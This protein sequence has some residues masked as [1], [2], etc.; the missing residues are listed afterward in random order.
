MDEILAI[1]GFCIRRLGSS[2]LTAHRA[3]DAP[4]RTN[5]W[6]RR[7]RACPHEPPR[8][9]LCDGFVRM[10]LGRCDARLHDRYCDAENILRGI[11]P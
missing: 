10:M 1:H 9:A 2:P 11:E 8:R 4:G 5:L 3:G 7:R 6:A